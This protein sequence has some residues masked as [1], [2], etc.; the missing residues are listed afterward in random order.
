MCNQALSRTATAVG[1]TLL[2]RALN[3]ATFPL[4]SRYEVGG[5]SSGWFHQSLS[6]GFVWQ[7]WIR[8]AAPCR[9]GRLTLCS[10]IA[11]TST[12]LHHAFGKQPT[13]PQHSNASTSDFYVLVPERSI[14]CQPDALPRRGR[15]QA[16]PKDPFKRSA[17]KAKP[18]CMWQPQS[19][20]SYAGY[21][22]GV[23][24]TAYQTLPLGVIL[25]AACSVL[26]CE[27]LRHKFA[28]RF[29]AWPR[30]T[31]AHTLD[32]TF[33]IWYFFNKKNCCGHVG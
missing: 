24:H 7:H 29:V 8:C 3:Q 13:S 16:L 15:L 28:V 25:M 2:L 21:Y 32:K 17:V 30:Q 18:L 27:S 6:P 23:I 14:D 5:L 11:N 20:V 19:I 1:T 33:I 9:S 10:C 26:A 4:H 31:Y 22:L 12:L